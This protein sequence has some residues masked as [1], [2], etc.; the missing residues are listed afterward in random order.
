MVSFPAVPNTEDEL[1]LLQLGRAVGH[2]VFFLGQEG[3]K[4]GNTPPK[5][6]PVFESMVGGYLARCKYWVGA[7]GAQ[8]QFK[9]W[10]DS[11]DWNPPPEPQ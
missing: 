5:S 6:L 1:S 9:I 10:H 11:L 2:A 7:P 3:G 4:L 8:S